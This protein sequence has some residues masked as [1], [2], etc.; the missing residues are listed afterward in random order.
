MAYEASVSVLF[1]SKERPRNGIFGFGRSKTGTRAKL[2]FLATFFQ[3][4]FIASSTSETTQ[5]RLLS[6]AT[7]WKATFVNGKTEA[8]E[9]L[10]FFKEKSPVFNEP[11]QA[12]Q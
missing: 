9:P 1:R 8:T 10:S 6:Q 3:W 11:N 5:K 4:S 7:C 12:R 2:S